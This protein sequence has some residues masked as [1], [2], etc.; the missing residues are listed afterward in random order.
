MAE[1]FFFL[2]GFAFCM[3]VVSSTLYVLFGVP[4]RLLLTRRYWWS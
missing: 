4:P 1:A 3:V 2:L